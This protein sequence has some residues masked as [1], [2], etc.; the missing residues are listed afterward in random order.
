MKLSG[1]L[2]VLAAA[3]AQ[4][5][6]TFAGTLY[7]GQ[8]TADWEAVRMTENR[9]HNGPITDVRSEAMTCYELNPGRGAARTLGVTAGSTVSI[10]TGGGT[11][12][13]H[14]GPT[15][16]YLA[17][18]P[19]GQTAATFSGKGA[20]WF[21]IAQ[22]QPRGLGTGSLSWETE[23]KSQVSVRIPQC[24]QNGEYLLRV[25]HIALHSASAPNGAQLYISCAQLN[26]SGG[27][28][29][30]KTGNLVAFPGAYSATDPGIL[31]NPYYP[32]PTRYINP[33]PAVATC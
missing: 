15:H 25:E 9:Y 11:S 28:G 5:H 30:I 18:V 20:V 3:G 2:A 24:V 4:A 12:I 8:R 32:I 29:S 33:G 27:S 19:A 14:P 16:F 22:D 21:K 13:F 17:K 7:N 10:T 31:F 26:I 23:G 6:Y 1:S